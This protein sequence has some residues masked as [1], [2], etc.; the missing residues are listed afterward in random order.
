MSLV[1]AYMGHAGDDYLVRVFDARSGK[2]IGRFT[3]QIGLVIE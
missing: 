1:S 3:Q 2:S